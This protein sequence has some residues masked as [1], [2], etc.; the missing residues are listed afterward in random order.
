M[1]ER[2]FRELRPRTARGA[3]LTGDRCPVLSAGIFLTLFIHCLSNFVCFLGVI[4]F[5]FAVDAGVDVI[6]SV[7]VVAVICQWSDGGGAG[8][9]ALNKKLFFIILPT[10][11]RCNKY[12]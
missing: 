5:D 12:V 2:K 3:E 8:P 4:Y 7:F 10:P 6:D 1:T 9:E 11:K